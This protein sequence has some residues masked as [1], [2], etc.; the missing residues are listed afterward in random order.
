M[1]RVVCFNLEDNKGTI[2]AIVTGKIKQ[3]HYKTSKGGLWT[4]FRV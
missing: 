2:Q 4:A 1:I 3:M